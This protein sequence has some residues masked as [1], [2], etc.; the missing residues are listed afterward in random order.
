MGNRSKAELEEENQNLREKLEKIYD[1]AADA[2]GIEEVEDEEDDA[3]D[4][5]EDDEEDESED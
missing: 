2:L 4:D 5:S 3:E 1:N